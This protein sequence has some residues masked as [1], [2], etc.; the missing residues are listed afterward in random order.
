[1][2]TREVENGSHPVE[3]TTTSTW[4]TASGGCCLHKAHSLT[5]NNEHAHLVRTIQQQI[6]ILNQRKQDLERR[7]KLA[8]S[9]KSELNST[10]DELG[11]KVLLLENL[12]NEKDLKIG[13]LA[14][15]INEL[16]DSSAWLSARLESMISLNERLVGCVGGEHA[17]GQMHDLDELKTIS[18]RD[19]SELVEQ[20]KELRLKR[21]SRIKANEMILSEADRR[22]RKS[23][24]ML[25]AELENGGRRP[26]SSPAGVGGRRRRQRLGRLLR[27]SP[28]AHDADDGQLTSSDLMSDDNELDQHNGGQHANDNLS[29]LISEIYLILNGFLIALQ[30]RKEALQLSTGVASGIDHSSDHNQQHHHH[31]HN[32]NEDSG[33]GSADE[34]GQQHR[35]SRFSGAN[36][37]GGDKSIG[38]STGGV[39]SP[40]PSDPGQWRKLINDVRQ[41]IDEMPCSSCQLMISERAD[42]EQ[43]QKLHTKVCEEIRLKNDEL[44]KLNARNIELESQLS[45]LEDKCKLLSDD[46][47]NCDKPKEEIVRLAWK[48]RDEA[49]TRKNNAEIQLA[50]TRIENMQISSQLMEVVQQKGELSQKLAQFEVSNL[51]GVRWPWRLGS[52]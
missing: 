4:P 11:D 15:A 39:Q 2:H 6:Q 36:S 46:L 12:L 8:Q 45:C 7:L 30:Q 23:A 20:L 49:V 31:Q 44:L 25:A 48:T 50:K 33:I 34:V 37:T 9:E 14:N 3:T 18:E 26:S 35:S 42:F 5:R 52:K 41:L 51:R 1:M 21:I 19:R 16:R 24:A 10:I 40:A 27:D 29:D 32:L 28:A 17:D 38:S 43:L 22:R 13:E 47:E